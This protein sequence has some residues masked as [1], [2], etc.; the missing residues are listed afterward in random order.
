VGMNQRVYP[1]FKNA[2]VRRAF[3][4]AINKKRIVADVL[5][6]LVREATSIVPPGV[7]GHRETAA[8]IPYD[9]AGARK[10]LAEAGYPGGKGLPTFIMEVRV[11]RKDYVDV[12]TAAATDL[13]NNLGIRVRVQP[14]EWGA[15]LERRDKWQIGLFHMRWAADY[16]DPQN[17]LSMMLGTHSDDPPFGPENRMDYS[18]PEFDRLCKEADSTMDPERRLQL[19]AQAEDIVLQDAPWV[20]I[21]YQR[22]AELI[23]P[24]IKGLRNS[25]FGHLPHYTVELE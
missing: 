23:R 20:P 25:L 17:F 5:G 13:Q 4:M 21:Y 14:S 16:L 1:Q 24:R 11:E 12:A 8:N 22:D 3:A 10:L 18:N 2:K 9:P 6:G 7:P 19:Y 15:Y